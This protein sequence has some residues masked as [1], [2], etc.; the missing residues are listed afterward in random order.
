MDDLPVITPDR[1]EDFRRQ[2]EEEAG[3]INVET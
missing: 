2:A 3:V 1:L